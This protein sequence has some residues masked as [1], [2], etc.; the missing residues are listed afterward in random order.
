MLW[1]LERV[2]LCT[3]VQRWRLC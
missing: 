2:K 1:T 3:K